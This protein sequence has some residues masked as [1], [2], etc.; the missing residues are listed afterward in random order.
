MRTWSSIF[1][2][3][4]RVHGCH[5]VFGDVDRRQRRILCFQLDQQSVRP[6]GVDFPAHVGE[7]GAALRLARR[8]FGAHHFAAVVVHA[9][10]VDRLGDDVEVAIPHLGRVGAVDCSDS[11]G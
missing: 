8:D 10:E 9:E 2:I 7:A 6:C 4:Q 1:A 3:L 5:A 11:S